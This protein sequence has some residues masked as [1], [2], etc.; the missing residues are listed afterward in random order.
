MPFVI[1]VLRVVHVFAAVYWV[2]VTFF[3]LANLEPTV[4]SAGAEGTRFM[5]RLATV[6]GLSR[7]TGIAGA[8]VVLTGLLMI[9]PVTGNLNPSV[10]F[11]SRLPLTLGALAGLASG[12]SGGL[13][14]GRSA[15]QMIRLG[16]AIAAQGQPPTPEQAAAL[17]RL[18]AAISSGTRLSAVLM[19]IALL[20]M[21][22]R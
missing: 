11:G 2:G 10:L 12:I 3:M 6:G 9:G 7:W 21:A 5:A 1:T 14:Q 13:I 16:A 17:G 15:A 20:G 19:T 22:W 4:K 18:Q 8:V